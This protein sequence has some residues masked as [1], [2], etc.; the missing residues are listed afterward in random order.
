MRF[1]IL[2]TYN[3][4]ASE[5]RGQALSATSHT[6]VVCVLATERTVSRYSSLQQAA[7]YNQH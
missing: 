4:T 5:M 1:V 7:V 3:G 6:V 2:T